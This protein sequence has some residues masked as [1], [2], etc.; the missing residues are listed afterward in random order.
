MADRRQKPGEPISGAVRQRR[1]HL[2]MRAAGLSR[3]GVWVPENRREE[4]HAIVRKL[5]AKWISEGV[6]PSDDEPT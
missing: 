4:F 6:Y 2:R 5:R 3:L 1:H